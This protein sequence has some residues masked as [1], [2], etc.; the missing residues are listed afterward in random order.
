MH[1]KALCMAK[2]AMEDACAKGYDCM[3]A[4]DW[5]NFKD[6]M[7]AAEKAVKAEYYYYLV[8]NIE[9]EKEY[10]KEEE[11]WLLKKLKE[12][13]GDDEWKR[14]YDA[15]RYRSSGR[16]AQ[17]GM[18][19]R[20][21]YEEPPYYHIPPEM[22]DGKSPERLRDFD[23]HDGRLYFTEIPSLGENRS[24]KEGKSGIKRKGYMEAKELHSGNT[25]EDKQ[26]KMRELEKYTKELA[27]DITEMIS[28]ATAEEQALLKNKIQVLLQKL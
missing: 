28:G 19:S 9:A 14:H 26:A 20:I 25:P 12:E 27:E 8:C 11:K 4:Q 17:R 24:E 10:E 16:F 2:H 6:C 18:G 1:K 7:E 21:G 15:W 3:T 13:Y 5:D 23:K 22:M